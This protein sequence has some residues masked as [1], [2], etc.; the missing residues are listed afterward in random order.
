MEFSSQRKMRR[1]SMLELQLSEPTARSHHSAEAARNPAM[2]MMKAAVNQSSSVG[3]G[4][5]MDHV[6]VTGRNR[7]LGD[8]PKM[9]CLLLRVFGPFCLDFVTKAQLATADQRGFPEKQADLA[10]KGGSGAGKGVGKGIVI[11]SP[12]I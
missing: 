4:K 9:T 10:A 6:G 7:I 12:T 3:M 11:M 5:I 2:S 1:K 8:G